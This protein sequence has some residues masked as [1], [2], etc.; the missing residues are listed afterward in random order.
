MPVTEVVIAQP[1]RKAWPETAEEAEK[2]KKRRGGSRER[3]RG[4]KRQAGQEIAQ[5]VNALVE[6]VL[7]DAVGDRSIEQWE[8]ALCK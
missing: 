2:R 3:R 7:G 4:R 5:G 8:P 6:H 1:I